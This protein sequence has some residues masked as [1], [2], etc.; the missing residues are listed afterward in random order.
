MEMTVDFGASS[1]IV[2]VFLSNAGQ[3]ENWMRRIHV[4]KFLLGD[5]LTEFS[6]SNV[7]VKN[8]I[9]AG[10]FFELDTVISGRYL[11]IRRD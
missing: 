6:T 10:G 3:A 4:S 11:S 9:V 5:D 7:V 8:N 2:S 1:K